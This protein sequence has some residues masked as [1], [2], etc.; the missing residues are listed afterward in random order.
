MRFQTPLKSAIVA[1]AGF[2]ILAAP[3]V[4]QD[5]PDHDV[6]VVVPFSAGGGT[7][8]MLRLF[9]ADAERIVGQQLN[10][11]NHPGAGAT[12]GWLHVLEQPADGYTIYSGSPTPLITIMTEE[13]PPVTPDQISV[14]GYIGAFAS[15]VTVRESDF[16]DWDAFVAASKER[17]LTIGGTNSIVMSAANTF[18]QAGLD[19]IYVPYASTG[20]AVTDFLGG[21]I[22]AV[23]L[24]ESTAS[25][26]VPE[27]AIAILNTSNSVMSQDMQDALGNPPMA[28]DLG[29][30][31]M[32]SP[33]WVGVHPDTPA[34]VQAEVAEMIEMIAMDPEVQKAWADA[35]EPIAYV[36]MEEAQADY[37]QLVESLRGTVS[38]LD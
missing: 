32:S 31:G 37:K 8:R 26:I 17:P 16:P 15:I 1:L 18:A 20:E 10:V 21:H 34:E 5:Y 7:D 6:T 36:G 25:T 33:R 38:L 3:A 22:D 12:S 19:I 29:Y 35:G 4:A 24:T 27:S 23:A 13:T 11:E 30:T 2:G 14:V 28:S 9:T